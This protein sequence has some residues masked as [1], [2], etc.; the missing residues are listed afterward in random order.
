[1]IKLNKI[2]KEILSEELTNRHTNTTGPEDDEYE[3][4]IVK[5]DNDLTGLRFNDGRFNK[6]GP[7]VIY[8]DDNPIVDF[9]VGELGQVKMHGKVFNNALYLQG[10]FNASEQGKGY[11]P[12][13]IEF[14][15]AKLPK[16]Q[17]I[18]LQCLDSIKPFWEH[19]GAVEI[20]KGPYSR[21]Q[22]KPYLYGMVITR[23]S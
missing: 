14:I 12:L 9:G 6:S 18:L 15:F 8:L 2:Y 23:P 17:Y 1:M 4:G 19:I 21:R 10:G 11:G 16:I 7:N 3:I 13:G 20:G 5:E 22:E